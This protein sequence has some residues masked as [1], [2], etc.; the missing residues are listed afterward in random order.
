MIMILHDQLEIW[1]VWLV[2]KCVSTPE[3]IFVIKLHTAKKLSNWSWE[4]WTHLALPA[5]TCEYYHHAV[6]V[7]ELG[8][9][10]YH[11][12]LWGKPI[13]LAT[14]WLMFPNKYSKRLISYFQKIY[15]NKLISVI[16]NTKIVLVSLWYW[17]INYVVLLT[18]DCYAIWVA[19]SCSKCLLFVPFCDFYR[20]ICSQPLWE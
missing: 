13:M 16:S 6:K 17:N 12:D 18:G 14:K 2:L 10:L 15:T 20:P 11:C 9:V 8:H 19:N 5:V 4:R 3:E 1:S 7:V